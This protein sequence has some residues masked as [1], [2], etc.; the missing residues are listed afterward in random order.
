MLPRKPAV[1]MKSRV[2]LRVYITC[3][4]ALRSVGR[5]DP[6][7]KN[8]VN[9]IYLHA[10]HMTT[11]ER[12]ICN[13]PTS[14]VLALSRPELHNTLPT[15]PHLNSPQSQTPAPHSAGKRRYVI[16]HRVDWLGAEGG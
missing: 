7:K 9:Y 1:V 8:N 5:T 13:I 2:T 12:R 3:E 15:H 14:E 10:R 11:T 6:N 4:V 16:S